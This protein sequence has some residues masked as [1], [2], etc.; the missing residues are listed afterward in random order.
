MGLAVLV[1]PL[2]ALLEVEALGAR[3][4]LLVAAASLAPLAASQVL[5]SLRL[6]PFAESA[7]RMRETQVG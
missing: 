6:G 1:A 7:S 2:A 4:W 3:G 5:A